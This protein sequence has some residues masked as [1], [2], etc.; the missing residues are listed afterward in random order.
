MP[1]GE[2]KHVRERGRFY[3]DKNGQPERALGTVIDITELKH[4]TDKLVQ[5]TTVIQQTGE[6]VMVADTGGNLIDVNP[7]FT[8]IT[9]YNRRRS[10][11]AIPVS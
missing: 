2:V 6:G 4:A 10:L 1:D 9:G 3:L 5:A 7:A 11:G 8:H